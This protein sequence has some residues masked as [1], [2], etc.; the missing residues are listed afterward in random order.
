ML[1]GGCACAGAGE[2]PAVVTEPVGLPGVW[3]TLL[4]EGYVTKADAN[5]EE[6]RPVML[7]HWRECLAPDAGDL[8]GVY[9][10]WKRVRDG[11]RGPLVQGDFLCLLAMRKQLQEEKEAAKRAREWRFTWGG[12]S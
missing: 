8:L 6:W 5:G 4:R 9:A 7:G 11:A 12:A 3:G 1:G 2:G 10:A